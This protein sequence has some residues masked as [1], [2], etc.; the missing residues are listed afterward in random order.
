LHSQLFRTLALALFLCPVLIFFS[1][2]AHADQVTLAWDASSGADGYRLFY[3]QDG[4]SYDYSSP[5]WEGAS[6]NCTIDLASDAN[7]Y[8]VVRS[9]NAYGESGNSNEASITIG[10]P[11][12]LALFD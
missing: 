7:Y 11:P 9:Y 2:D 6:T 3:R 10:S 12:A 4:Q 8:L 5:D 1:P